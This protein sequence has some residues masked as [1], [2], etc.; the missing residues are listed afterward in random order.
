MPFWRR[1]KR[2]Q[3]LDREIHSHLEAEA[4]EQKE[5]GMAPDE[6]RY[7]AQRVLGNATLIKENVR[8]TWRSSI[9]ERLGQDLRYAARTLWRD[10]GFASIAVLTLAFG[11]GAN[12]AIFSVVNAVLLRPLPYIHPEQLVNVWRTHGKGWVGAVSIP[13]LRDWQEQNTVLGGIAAYN[14][15]RF[16]L[17]GPSQ[18]ETT[19]GAYVSP[20]F[21]DVMRVRPL[22]GRRFANDED[23]PGRNHVIA[24]SY[25]LWLSQFGGNRALVGKDIRLNADTYTVVGVMPRGFH[26]PD[27]ATNLWIPLTPATA[28][29]RRDAHDFLAIGRLK[30]GVSID[31]ARTQL[32]GISTRLAA[33][34]PDTDSE[35]GAFLIPLESESVSRVHDSLLI[36]FAA[37]GFIFLI[38][39]ANVSIFL[40]SRAAAR[41]REIAVRIAL[42]VSRTRLAAQFL[43]ESLLL[44]LCGAILAALVAHWSVTS[45][46]KLGSHY[47][48]D[49][50]SIRPDQ[51][52]F[53]FTLA[54][55]A[56]AAMLLSAVV[57]WSGTRVNVNETLKEGAQTV[58]GG[59]AT[60]R[61]QR[62]LVVAQMGAAFLLLIG[63][64]A[65]VESLVNLSRV[66]P[67]F[68]P[69]H[70]LTMRIPLA[71][72]KHTD[73]HPASLL[74]QPLLE[75]IEA[76]PGVK[77]A[78]VITYLPMQ[79]HGTNS[80]FQVQGKP[81]L[82]EAQEP[83][84]EV[85]AISP[86]YYRVMGI[87]LLRGRWIR[88][89]DDAA[90]PE[91]AVV[92]KTFVNRYFPTEDPLGKQIQFV[93]E[94][95]WTTIV[96]VVED[97]H[98]AGLGAPPLPEADLPYTQA[99]W[100]YLTSTMSLAVRTA[101]DP[102]GMA[103]AIEHAVYSVDPD[104]GVFDLQTM[105]AVI[106]ATE[107]DQRF[108]LLLLGLFAGLA[109][110][111]AASGL[112]GQMSYAVTERTHEIGVRIALGARRGDVLRLIAAQGARLAAYGILIGLSTSFILTRL[113]G[114]RLYGIEAL[115]PVPIV[116]AAAMLAAVTL[117]ACYIPA[118]RAA[119]VDPIVALRYE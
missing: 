13:D 61:R 49:P 28:E 92:N 9:L 2:E 81:A 106:A 110:A 42:G 3:D 8:A 112:F 14:T 35:L 39:C 21:F 30:P 18:P 62:F 99:R 41:R 100:I 102:L 48:S 109:L 79:R 104:Q 105:N 67:G 90:S 16:S 20:N 86:D 72:A 87:R 74:F 66:N 4:A 50:G 47:F 70:V 11:I 33:A 82:P 10:R 63:T 36:L 75:R 117:L 57:V 38:A 32:N 53:G 24:L 84:A 95:R 40:L 85:R 31:Q 91:V 94:Q 37:V 44:A 118:R 111:L 58:A 83:W 119:K 107:A 77:S 88:D 80:R 93:D 52:V 101:S 56:L 34:Y 22:M 108:V 69:D 6:A 59:R 23:I 29:L 12:T 46:V 25:D 1:N 43:V 97:S 45:I 27:P 19:E 78:A 7:A 71:P 68:H 17:R 114:S 15:D 26:Y 89:A 54:L 116:I 73:T 5:R 55:A 96:G 113:L 65:M 76:L 64:G 103:N 51:T 115:G 98:Q 60:V